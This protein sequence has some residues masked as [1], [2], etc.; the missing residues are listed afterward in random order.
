MAFGALPQD[1]AEFMLGSVVVTP[2]FFE[3]NGTIDT[4]T[5][6][7]T[8][9]TIQQTLDKITQATDWWVQTLASLNTVHHLSFTIDT[10]FANTPFQTAYEPINRRSNDYN[11]YVTEF[12][13]SQGA[14]TTDIETEMFKFNDAQR[15]KYNTDWSF[16]MIVVNSYTQGTGQFAAGGLSAEHSRS[17]AVY[18]W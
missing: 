8:P 15:Q 6:D 1:T 3:S 4:S 10:T 9:A 11:R 16:T 12:L 13:Q 2:V 7:W 18:F 17:L 14:T 5:E